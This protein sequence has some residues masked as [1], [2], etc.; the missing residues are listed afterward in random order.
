MPQTIWLRFSTRSVQNVMHDLLMFALYWSLSYCTHYR[1]ILIPALLGFSGYSEDPDT[2][3]ISYASPYGARNSSISVA[4]TNEGRGIGFYCKLICCVSS[5]I[6]CQCF[7]ILTINL[8]WHD[9]FKFL[10]F[11]QHAYISDF[12][13]LY[14]T[15]S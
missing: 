1:C 9:R 14:A 10:Y 2:E 15:Y 12:N 11:T 4:Y 13:L 3:T 8:A 7:Y 6:N 5:R